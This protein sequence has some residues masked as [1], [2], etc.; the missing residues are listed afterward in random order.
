MER[1]ARYILKPPLCLERMKYADGADEV[2]YERKGSNGEKG[3]EE[4]FDPLDFLARVIA[5][6][7]A[8]R[9]HLVRY[10]GHYSNVARGRRKK[11]K[12]APLTP[13]HPREREDDGLSDVQRRARRRAWARLIRRVYEI[14][15]LVCKNCGGSMRIISVILEPKVITKIL[16]H[17]AR[18]GIKPG[19]APPKQEPN[20]TSEPF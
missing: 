18:K 4:R 16:S 2:V 9:S 10:I 3:S 8:P 17:L 7:P 14:D 1:M 20:S 19:R 15:P 13:A 11:G 12:E 5:H 6:I